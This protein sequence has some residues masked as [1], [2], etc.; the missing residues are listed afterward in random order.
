MAPELDSATKQLKDGRVDRRT[1]YHEAD[2][3]VVGAGVFGTAIAFAMAN[4]GRSVLLL[5]RWMKQP[6]RIVGELLQPGGCAA[7][8]KLGLGHCLEGID[9]IPCYG[10]DVIYYGDECRLQ[11]PKISKANSQ[12]VYKKEAHKFDDQELVKPEGRSFHHGRFINELRKSCLAHPNITVVETE[13]TKPVHSDRSDV[14]LGVEARTVNPATGQKEPDYFF[15]GL[16]IVADGYDSKFRKN[17]L[18]SKPL[19]RS[20]FYAL[21]LIDCPLPAPNCGHVIIGEAAPVLLYQIGT[22]ETRALIDVPINLPEASAAQGG[23]RSYIK[24]HVIPTLPAQVQPSMLKA[25]SDGKIPRSM[26]NSWLPAQKQRANGMIIAGDALNMRH[27]LTGG[28]MTV[29][30]NDAVIISQLLSPDKIADLSDTAA[31][32][33]AMSEFY[34]SRKSL[35]GI[36][37]VLAQALYSLFS[38]NSRLL[39]ALQQGCFAYFKMG[40]TEGPMGLLG[41]LIHSPMT[42]FNHFFTVAFLSIWLNGWNMVVNNVAGFVLVPL[43][44]MDLVFILWKASVV[45]LPVFYHELT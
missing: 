17:H 38:A 42:L 7:L 30:L 15:G 31:V 45:I 40:M 44:V 20:K 43:A 1:K 5:E 36:I 18:G 6:D 32:N 4:Q 27:P 23:V 41:G 35:T 13:V 34:W 29:A 39:R 24:N 3:V 37:N 9:A 2:V 21:E 33:Q 12:V 25:L 26:P 8:R 10:F 19:V 14:I 16:T 11:Y 22:H 28:G